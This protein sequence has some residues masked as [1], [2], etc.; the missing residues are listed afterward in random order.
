MPELNVQW[1]VDAQRRSATITFKSDQAFTVTLEVAAVEGL[2]QAF[3]LMR[4]HLLPEPPREFALGTLSEA[5]RDPIINTELDLKEG[6]SLI[7]LRDERYGW[8]HYLL[9]RDSARE[10]GRLLQAQAAAQLPEQ[11]SDK[12]N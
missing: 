5:L 1:S 4:G 7:H 12:P 6:G 10:L 11:Q 8:L 2:L 3:G 9:P